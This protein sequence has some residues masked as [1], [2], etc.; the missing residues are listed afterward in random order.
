MGKKQILDSE[1]SGLIV[2]DTKG[3]ITTKENSIIIINFVLTFT[4]DLTYKAYL[5]G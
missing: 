3:L 5:E 2:R 1:L 4:E